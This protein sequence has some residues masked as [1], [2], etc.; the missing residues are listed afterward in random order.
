MCWF[1]GHTKAYSVWWSNDPLPLSPLHPSSSFC[2]IDEWRGDWRS[3]EGENRP[4]RLLWRLLHSPVIESDSCVTVVEEIH[5]VSGSA[6]AFNFF[7]NVCVCVSVRLQAGGR[8]QG[9]KVVYYSL[10]LFF[11]VCVCP[12]VCVHLHGF[13][14][15][16]SHINPS[17]ISWPFFM[18]C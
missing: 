14:S 17:C 16:Y 6:S 7:I 11:K 3:G 4:L 18:F 5:I 9:H 1:E 8:H 2:S 12:V 13:R 10:D 15:S